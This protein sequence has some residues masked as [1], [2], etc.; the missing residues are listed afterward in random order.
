MNTVIFVGNGPNL[1]DDK[2]KQWSMILDELAGDT[3]DKHERDLRDA[4]PFTLWFEEILS[5]QSSSNS[6]FE[7]VGD[8][9]S[10]MTPNDIHYKIMSIPCQNIITTNYDHNLESVIN[11]EWQ[12]TSTARESKYSLFRRRSN[13]SK[14]IWHIHGEVSLTGTIMLGH[15]QY[16][17]YMQ[18]IRNFLTQG[19]STQLKERKGKPYYSKFSKDKNRNK[20]YVES[21]VDLF[22]ESEVHM[23]GFGLDYTEN[24]LWNLIR[25]KR[26]LIKSGKQC[27][28]LTFHRCTIKKRDIREEAKTSLLES[29][30]V[31]VREHKTTSYHASYSRALD[32]ILNSIKGS[33]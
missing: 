6:L 21:W 7:K 1:I 5:R 31:L 3:T 19:V 12:T 18:K 15:D 14:H 29:F 4:K 17:G 28:K 33:S 30:G 27:G 32:E 13:D 20:D 16:S 10:K 11:G 8:L 25:K 22:L 26:D 24:H 9:V 2:G 23:I